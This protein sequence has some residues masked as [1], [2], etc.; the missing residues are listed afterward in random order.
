M[1]YGN[2]CISGGS[3]GRRNTGHNFKFNAVL[4]KKIEFF[5]G[6]GKY[7]WIAAFESHDGWTNL[8]EACHT[9]IYVVL[10]HHTSAAVL[11]EGDFHGIRPAV[12][13]DGGIYQIVV[14]DGVGALENFD[15]AERDEARIARSG[16]DQI[17]F[18]WG[19]WGVG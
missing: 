12:S 1:S 2:A 3:E 13:E 5:A 11:A 9:G 14:K 7:H 16:T 6:A 19:H 10:R 17:D 15:A 4:A 8:N 18:S